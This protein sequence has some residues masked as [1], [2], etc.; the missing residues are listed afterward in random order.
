MFNIHKFVNLHCLNFCQRRPM[1]EMLMWSFIGPQW[2]ETLSWMCVVC[3]ALQPCF[4]LTRA[5]SLS[6]FWLFLVCFDP[7]WSQ[8]K[9]HAHGLH[10]WARARPAHTPSLSHTHTHTHARTHTR[11]HAHTHNLQKAIIFQAWG[12]ALSLNLPICWIKP[13]YVLRKARCFY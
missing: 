7:L 1:C 9:A 5:L 8:L 12:H 13:Q 3:S 2:F 11:K 6:S 10:D 4:S